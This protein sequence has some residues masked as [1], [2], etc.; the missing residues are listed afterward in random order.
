MH[1]AATPD[2]ARAI[3]KVMYSVAAAGPV[4]DADRASIN[5]AA[6]YI[7]RL[8]PDASVM[9]SPSAAELQALAASPAIANEAASFAT[10]MAFVDGKLD[11]A[12]LKAVLALA[13]KLGVKQD[14]V[15]DIAKLAQGHVRDATAHMIRAN[16]ES[17]TG[18]PVATDDEVPFLLPYKDKPDP[19]LAARFHALA[20]LP[21]DTFGYTFATFYKANKYAFPGEPTALNFAFAAPHDSSHTLAGYDTTPRGELLV[22]TFTAAMHRKRAMAGHVL[23]VILS[24]HLGIALNEVA[25]AAKGAL[26]PTEFWHAW[27]RGEAIKVDLFDPSWDFW[28]AT[29]EPVASV[30]ARIGMTA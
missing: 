11:G 24:W 1:I 7:F 30:R 14:Y 19:A 22:S 2:Q 28:A 6:R 25:G 5:G 10:V 4:T 15:D 21:P 8:G 29:R 12:K 23:P 3:L 26:D 13:G 16:L 18:H 20:D 17:I 9:A 27:S